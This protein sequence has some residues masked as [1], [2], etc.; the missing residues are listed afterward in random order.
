MQTDHEQENARQQSSAC[1]AVRRV[2]HGQLNVSDD[3]QPLAYLSRVAMLDRVPKGAL[4]G[5]S[6]PFCLPDNSDAVG[7]VGIM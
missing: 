6:F 4:L 1:S 5:L 3:D 7:S 2:V